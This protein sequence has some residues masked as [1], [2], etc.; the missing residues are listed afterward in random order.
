MGFST[1]A[2]LCCALLTLGACASHKPAPGGHAGN[3]AEVGVDQ[4]SR[5]LAQARDLQ[6]S[7]GCAKAAPVYRIVASYGAGHDM[8]QFELGACLL[9]MTGASDAETALFRQEALFWLTRAAWAGNPRAQG[10][11]AESLSGARP[12]AVSFLS[13]DPAEAMKWSIIYN[14]N[15]VRDVYGL[16]TLSSA[17]TDHLAATLDAAAVAK[18][19][20][21]AAAF[22][23]IE[24]SEFVPM[25]RP[26]ENGNAK[27]PMGEGHGPGGERRRR[28]P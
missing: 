11:L 13:A 4:P 5:L 9:M 17:V 1:K 26:S 18:A 2:A 27:G 14:A 8:A 20:A 15:G 24:M 23:K 12:F 22:T 6:A 19:Q 10:K 25:A 28:G 3:R 7:E 21:Q 16:Q